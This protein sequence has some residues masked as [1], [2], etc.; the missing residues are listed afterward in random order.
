MSAPL[1]L[2]VDDDPGVRQSLARELRVA[3]YDVEIAS[4]GREG[5]SQASL[6]DPAL[7]V[8][9]L[10]MPRADGFALVSAVR[11][12]SRTPIIVVSVRGRDDDK[13]RALDLGA[14]DYVTKPFSMPELLARVRAQLRR[15]TAGADEKV[16]RFPDLTIDLAR[17][18]VVQGDRE[19]RLTP[20]ELAILELLARNA[21][22]P[23]TFDQII[24]R[25]WGGTAEA[26][27]DAVRTH[28]GSL[29]RKLEPDPSN[30]RY[31]VNEP[32]IGYRFIAEPA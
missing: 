3:G 20:T 32:W 12:S 9:D 6:L 18:R 17:R 5:A 25:V 16:L 13:V 2:V 26:T 14:D 8:T 23:L 10:A 11:A 1:V 31:V 4:D 29:R 30:P 21:G 27:R 24:S 7:I 28:V 22:R 19:I 15:T